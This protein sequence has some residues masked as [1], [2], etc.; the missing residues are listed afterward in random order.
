METTDSNT[1]PMSLDQAVELMVQ[2]EETT[3]AEV[4]DEVEQEQPVEDSYEEAEDEADA[5]VEDV[6]P[7]EVEEVDDDETDEDDENE[8]EDAEEDDESEDPVGDLHTV[9]VDGEE[10][11]VTLDELKR[12]YSG[13]QYVQKGMQQAAEAKKEAENVYYALMQ[14]RQ[15]LANLVQQVQSGQNLTPPQEPDSAMF[16][17]DPIG[18]MEAKIQYDNQMKAYQQNIG[19]VQE[20]MQKQSEAEQIARAE[21][22]RQEAQKLVQVI[23]ELADA[24]KAGKFKENLVRTA[25]DVYGYTPEEIAGISSHRDFL[26]LRDAMKYREMMAGKGEVQK[27]VQKAKPAIKP[28]A[29]KVSTKTDAVRK[30]KERLKKSGSIDDA[31]ALIMQN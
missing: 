16:D 15:N 21:Y 22:A 3:E 24:G 4:T 25:T 29:K 5:E 27:K 6:D 28:G 19:Q 18:Y 10:K 2:P 17:A 13:Q 14:E 8:Y 30:Q 11:Q 1:G 20:V 31:L 7:D 12:G 26:V 9:K 23:P